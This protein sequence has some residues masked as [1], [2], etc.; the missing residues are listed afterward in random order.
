M[1]AMNSSVLACSYAISGSA[2][3]SELN[4]KIASMPSVAS[5]GLNKL[6]VIRAQMAS[7]P[8]ESRGNEAKKAAMA[9]LAVTLFTTSVA[10]SS[11]NAGVIEEAYTVEFGTCKFPENFTGCQDLAKQKGRTNTSVVPMYSG[12]GED[13]KL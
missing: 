7:A 12:N 1:A 9:F 6:P 4:V 8:K 11:A 5:P 10:S 3:S 13:G 2:G